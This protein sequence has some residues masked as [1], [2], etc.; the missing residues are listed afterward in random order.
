MVLVP[1]EGKL[2]FLVK[3]TVALNFKSSSRI[4]I[5]MYTSRKDGLQ[6]EFSPPLVVLFPVTLESVSCTN[7]DGL[8]SGRYW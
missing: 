4:D 7:Q 1:L 3:I 6:R 5:L 2:V 8:G